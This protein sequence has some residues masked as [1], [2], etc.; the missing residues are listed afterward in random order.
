MINQKAK[1]TS[2][3]LLR[4]PLKDDRK[5]DQL[6]QAMQ[7]IQEIGQ[8][9]HRFFQYSIKLYELRTKDRINEVIAY[10]TFNRLGLGQHSWSE[11]KPRKQI[12]YCSIL[13]LIRHGVAVG[14]TDRAGDKSVSVSYQV[15]FQ[16]KWLK[17][18]L[19]IIVKN[20]KFYHY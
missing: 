16:K 10:M 17:Q 15:S 19:E 8:I 5:I 2:S 7:Q 12:T 18:N 13:P 3:Q 11:D 4:L 1:T 20:Y 6:L 9:L 14:P